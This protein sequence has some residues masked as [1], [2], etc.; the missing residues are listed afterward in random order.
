MDKE[1]NRVRKEERDKWA[2]KLREKEEQLR[3]LKKQH[4]KEQKMIETQLLEA[5]EERHKMVEKY[6]EKLATISDQLEKDI[7]EQA[8]LGRIRMEE[9]M[10]RWGQ[11]FDRLLEKMN[12]KHLLVSVGVGNN[13]G[14]WFVVT[15]SIGLQTVFVTDHDEILETSTTQ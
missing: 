13:C 3:E 15:V 8:E 2:E 14:G 10:E 12:M 6:E 1:L 7:E 5:K 11:F 4:E 9:A